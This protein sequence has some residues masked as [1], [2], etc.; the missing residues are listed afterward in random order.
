M[1]STKTDSAKNR[2]DI[3]KV[4]PLIEKMNAA[5]EI[6]SCCVGVE[7]L[8]ETDRE[9]DGYAKRVKNRI[10]TGYRLTGLVLLVLI[11]GIL[12]SY[13]RH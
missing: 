2:R 1:N 3:G 5:R 9:I 6:S 12:V 10:R 4:I 13:V 11:G 8:L 7:A